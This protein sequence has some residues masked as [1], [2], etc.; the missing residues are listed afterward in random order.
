MTACRTTLASLVLLIALGIP[1]AGPDAQTPRSAQTPLDTYVAKPDP[2]F[3]WKVVRTIAGDGYTTFVV[4]LKSQA[5]LTER[6]VDR[7]VWQHWLVIVKPDV[8]KHDTALLWIGGG[9]NGSAIPDAANAR[10]VNYALTTN[11]VVADL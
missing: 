1:L 7:T 9:K 8:V 10:T 3:A 4:D 11:T 6:E 5:W 2:T